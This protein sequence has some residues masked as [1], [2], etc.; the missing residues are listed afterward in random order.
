MTDKK[1]AVEIITFIGL[2][3]TIVFHPLPYRAVLP[4]TT[5]WQVLLTVATIPLDYKA[6]VDF[7]HLHDR[8]YQLYRITP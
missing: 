8:L 5:L 2:A 6:G 1:Q 7:M 4:I 3:Q